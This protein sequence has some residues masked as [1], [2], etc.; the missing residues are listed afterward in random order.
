VISLIRF[1][2]LSL[3][4]FLSYGAAPTVINLDRPGTTLILGE[5]MDDTGRG[6]GAN[7]VGLIVLGIQTRKL[8]KSLDYRMICSYGLLPFQPT[9]YLSWTCLF[10]T[11]LPLTKLI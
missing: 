2:S 6:S 5:N 3:R 11:Q 7:G 10:D 1:T 4:N 8:K 9:I